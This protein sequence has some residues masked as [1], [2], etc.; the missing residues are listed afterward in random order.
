MQVSRRTSAPPAADVSLDGDLT[1]YQLTLAA[2]TYSWV[3]QAGFNIALGLAF[4]LVGGPW[5]A[6]GWTL[7]LCAADWALQQIYRR[8]TVAAATVSSRR[9]L[10]GLSWL[11]FVKGVFWYAVPAGFTALTHS[12]AGL[13]FV[14][15]QA[16]GLT[17]LAVSTARNSQRI[18]LSM[19]IGTV[20]ALSVSIVATVGAAHGAGAL[21]ETLILAFAL[22]LVG[23]G[24]SQVVSDWN[25]ANED[26]FQAMIDM[27]Q[28]LMRSEIAEAR[29]SEALG[30][31]EA[32]NRAKSEFLATMSH[33]I[34]TP[35]NGVLGM[36]QVMHRGELSDAQR[37]HLR[38]ISTAGASLLTLL[39]DLLDL[40]KIDAGKVELE[41]GVIDTEALAAGLDTFAPLLQDKDVVLSVTV[42]PEALGGWSG[43]PTRVRQVLHNL[44]SNAVKFTDHG[45]ISVVISHDGAALILDVEDTGAGI[46]ATRLAQVFEPFVQADASTTRRYGGSGLGLTICRDLLTLMGG[47]IDL[48]STEGVGS[49]FTVRLPGR[50]AALPVAAI[51][52]EA[53]IAIA[54]GLR[55]LAA[56]DNPM[57]QI[58]LRTLLE[59][60]DIQVV[61]VSN[62]EEAVAAWRA[63]R[64]DLVLMDVQMPVMDGV[65]A[66]RIIREAERDGGLARTPII[67]LTANAMDH[68][69]SEYLGAGMDALVAK[70]INLEVLLQTMQSLLAT[71][72]GE[73]RP[74]SVNASPARATIQLFR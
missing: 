4:C 35:L 32:A 10:A 37:E 53:P 71:D 51:E 55:V 3:R 65:E 33:E 30:R 57:N 1:P 34:R 41:D 73:E 61:M 44:I 50:R 45:T 72:D 7:S 14:G 21:F 23:S 13:A 18:F 69:R 60:G 58:V 70:P 15:V 40:S 74:A 52:A 26:R 9:G 24:T 46:S 48:V 68:H 38:M 49:K 12:L 19:V 39:N 5:V 22:W 17:A 62:G 31:A 43:D 8:L 25:R 29:A 67:A 20:T 16:V 11:M 27:R 42:A 64:W 56:E 2:L 54:D 36:A 47:T 6:L 66:T 28:A 63:G 59:A